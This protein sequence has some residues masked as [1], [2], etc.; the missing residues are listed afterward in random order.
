VAGDVIEELL[1]HQLKSQSTGR[2]AGQYRPDVLK[3]ILDTV[4]YGV[5]LPVPFYSK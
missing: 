2:Y 3:P 4:D 5:A 1:G